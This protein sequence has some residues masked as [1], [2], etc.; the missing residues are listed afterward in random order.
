[1]NN[2]WRNMQN[3]GGEIKMVGATGFEPVCGFWF[4]RGCKS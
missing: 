2:P 3:R 4:A 1:M